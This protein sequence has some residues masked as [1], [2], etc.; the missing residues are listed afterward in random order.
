MY[1]RTIYEKT[2]KCKKVARRAK[3]MLYPEE[4]KIWIEESVMEKGAENDN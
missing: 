4:F 3:T 2:Y 1:I